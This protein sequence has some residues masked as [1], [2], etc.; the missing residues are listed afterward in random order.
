MDLLNSTTDAVTAAESL[1]LEALRDSLIG[2]SASIA[3]SQAR[4]ALALAVFKA[5]GGDGLGSGYSSFG[6]WASVD[7][8]LSSR[9]AANLAAAGEAVVAMPA[10]RSAWEAGELSTSKVATLVTVAT[11]ESEAAW[12]S[13]ALDASAGQLSRIASAYR[14]SEKDDDDSAESGT[15]RDER[16]GV[17]WNTRDDGLVELLAI[18]E[19]EDA[20]VVRAALEANIEMDWRKRSR[21]TSDP[22]AEAEAAKDAD[23]PPAPDPHAEPEAESDTDTGADPDASGDNA[24]TGGELEWAPRPTAQRMA[25]ALLEL[26]ATGLTVGPV[27]IVRGEHTEVVVHVDATLLSGDATVGRCSLN[28]LGGLDLA[29]A[30]RLACDAKLRAMVHGADGTAVDLGRMQRLVSDKQRRLLMERDRGCTFPG[31]P[32]HR[33]VDAHH[34]EFWEMGGRTDM[35][36]LALLCSRHHRLLHREE[37]S[38]GANGDGTFVFRDKWGKRI[39][40]PRGRP[41]ADLTRAV[42]GSTRAR[43]GGDPNYS[44]NLAVT[45][46]AG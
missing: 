25:D 22:E 43:F 14:R 30:R 3:A 23:T 38:I 1:E 20:A 29:G 16:C 35:A 42:D 12:C 41:K 31:C 28:N 13:M 17:W 36:N 34:V 7:L 18:L 33:Y 44:V 26:A 8:G 46:L 24:A 6:Q 4:F 15:S 11:E 2:A 5:R 39:G 32:N 27:P 9:A 37:F 19:P 10:V 40:P 45:A 21:H